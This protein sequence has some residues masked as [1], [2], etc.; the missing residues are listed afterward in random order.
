MSF[1]NQHTMAALHLVV[2][3]NQWL[4]YDL[5]GVEL[6]DF[7]FS[8]V[9]NSWLIF[10]NSWFYVK[11]FISNAVIPWSLLFFQDIFNDR[12]LN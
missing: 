9:L 7:F 3:M 2:S 1:R 12:F 4:L 11:K 6:N 10:T 5:S 8:N